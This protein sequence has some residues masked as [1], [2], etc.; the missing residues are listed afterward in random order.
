MRDAPASGARPPIPA[1]RPVRVGGSKVPTSDLR[2]RQRRVLAGG[3]SVPPQ[4]AGRPSGSLDPV[5]HDRGPYADLTCRAE[6][7]THELTTNPG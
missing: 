5:V 2:R 4:V 1:A 6:H 3:G 7:G